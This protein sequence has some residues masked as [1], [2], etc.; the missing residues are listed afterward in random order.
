MRS[1]KEH[2]CRNPIYTYKKKSVS[3]NMGM[4]EFNYLIIEN[5]LRNL[6]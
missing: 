2:G 1:G 3:M 6:N 4:Q 5:E